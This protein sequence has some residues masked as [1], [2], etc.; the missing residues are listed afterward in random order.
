M[1]F[2]KQCGTQLEDG[3]KFCPMCGANQADNAQQQ[4]AS[5]SRPADPNVANADIEQNK[6]MAVLAY[7]GILALIP[8]FAAPDS[9]FARYHAIQGLNLLILEAV[10]AVV[11]AILTA[12]FWAISWILGS[13]MGTILGLLWIF[14][15]VM[16]IFGII[17]ACQGQSKPLPL[18]GEFQI[19]KK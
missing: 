8:Y 16:A 13:V 17:N 3:A 11:Y 1:A 4:S 14:F 15:V 2:C 19:I 18:I 5:A 7:I 10:Y 6:F 9:K 12:I